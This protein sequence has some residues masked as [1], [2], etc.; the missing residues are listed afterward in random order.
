MEIVEAGTEALIS[1]A[2]ELV[3]EY[4]HSLEFDLGFQDFDAEL[5]NFPRQYSPPTGCLVLA[6][7]EEQPVGC[8]GVRYL[9]KTICE[10]KRLYVRPRFRGKQAGKALA[11][12]AIKTGK[13]LG[14]QRM[15]LDTVPSMESANRL[16]RS[17]GFVEI[18]PYR[19]NPIEGATYLELNLK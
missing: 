5:E 1:R 6:L 9:E 19:H 11:Q 14:Y 18:G 13:A 7:S 8:V 16:Y 17:L 15:R 2:K 4:S 12:A 3:L 10:M